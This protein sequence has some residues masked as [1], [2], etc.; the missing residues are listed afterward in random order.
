MNHQEESKKADDTLPEIT[1]TQAYSKTKLPKTHH[2]YLPFFYLFLSSSLGLGIILLSYKAS[3]KNDT[4]KSHL[5]LTV[6]LIIS[7]F[8]II[9]CLKYSIQIILPNT[10]LFRILEEIPEF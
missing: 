5:L 1:L 6:G 7:L 2:S 3:F 8:S 9:Y 10:R 4:L